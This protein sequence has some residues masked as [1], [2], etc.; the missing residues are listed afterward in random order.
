MERITILTIGTFK[1]DENDGKTK[2]STKHTKKTSGNVR[3]RFRFYDSKKADF[4]YRSEIV[5]DLKDLAKFNNDGTLKAGTKIYDPVLVKQIANEI[6]AMKRAYS[7]MKQGGYDMTSKVFN[8]MV[9]RELHPEQSEPSKTVTLL[10][11]FNAFIEDSYRQGVWGESR[12]SLYK[13]VAKEVE[14]FLTVKGRTAITPSDFTPNDVMEYRQFIVD[15][16]KYVKKWPKLYANEPARHI[17]NEP[18]NQNTA[19][20]RVKQLKAFFSALEDADEIAKSPFR[21]L[22]KDRVK[23]ATKE[24]YDEPVFLHFEEFMAVMNTDVPESH[25]ETKDAFLLQCAFGCRVADFQKLSM[26]NVG[27]DKHGIPYIHYLPNKTKKEQRD[28]S[29]IE[30]PI[31]RYALDIVKKYK[32]NFHIL[33]YVS[34]EWG[35]NA[36]IKQ[37]LQKC[38]IDRECNVYNE[39]IED[40]EYKPLYELASSKLCRKTH[41]DIMNKAQVNLY[42]AGLH[43]I[44]SDAVNRYTKLELSD[45][46]KLMCFAFGQPEYKVDKSLNVIDGSIMRKMKPSTKIQNWQ[47]R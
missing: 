13:L 27:V 9:F 8:E 46:F 6:D 35:Y 24:R 32:F 30:T 1:D 16:Y 42:A 43:R 3:L 2:K 10:E 17:P 12:Y 5:A 20:T 41:V 23:M 40:N 4:S 21:K 29:E 18:R 11:R 36:K 37:L 44:G 26:A 39:E 7:A 47:T 25:R 14:R 15:E 28:N 34:G 38:G 33:H 22:G 31:I 19:A 45:K